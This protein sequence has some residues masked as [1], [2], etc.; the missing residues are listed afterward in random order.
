MAGEH[1]D[2]ALLALGREWTASVA[3]MRRIYDSHT[4]NEDKHVAPDWPDAA[5]WRPDELYVHQIIVPESDDDDRPTG[6]HRYSAY[7]GNTHFRRVIARLERERDLS[8]FDKQDLARAREIVAALEERHAEYERRYEACGANA[9]YEALKVATRAVSLLVNK[10]AKMRAQTL[11]GVF[12][13]ARA[14]L[15][16][17]SDSLAELDEELR[18]LRDDADRNPDEAQLGN[19]L[20]VDL[21][22]LDGATHAVG[23]AVRA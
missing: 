1:P 11:D 10:I 16:T 2:E 20:L 18:K 23:S 8:D 9:S 12:V 17:R 21:I 19:L 5:Y 14:I 3:E 13:K 22:S 7:D 6:R 4:A 15:W